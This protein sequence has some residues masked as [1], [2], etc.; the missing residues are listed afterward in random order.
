MPQVEGYENAY[1]AMTWL[2]PKGYP[3][4]A[5]AGRC[6]FTGLL[7]MYRF[8]GEDDILFADG[9]SGDGFS[10]RWWPRWGAP[11]F[12]GG[13]AAPLGLNQR[14]RRRPGPAILL[15]MKDGVA[16][17]DNVVAIAHQ[18]A[19]AEIPVSDAPIRLQHADGMVGDSMSTGTGR[20]VLAQQFGVKQFMGS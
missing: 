19:R 11:A 3:E 20:R 13:L 16:R 1:Y 8:N 7:G 14:A 5:N 18:P 10:F 15:G 17:P 6:Y 4:H 2:G 9:T 12:N